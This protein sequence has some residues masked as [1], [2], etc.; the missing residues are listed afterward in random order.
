M[1]NLPFNFPNFSSRVF[2]YKESKRRKIRFKKKTKNL[3]SISFKRL[4]RELKTS[5]NF[6]FFA[7]NKID[8][9][10]QIHIYLPL[11]SDIATLLTTF[12][13][14]IPNLDTS[15]LREP[16]KVRACQEKALQALQTYTL[17][18][19]HNLPSKFGELLL[20]IPELQRTCQVSFKNLIFCFI[21]FFY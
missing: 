13:I 20:R 8:L 11:V 12:S 9:E 1:S 3:P 19:Y 10:R 16:E 6:R 17:A 4:S 18:H 15:D 14:F 21:F 2:F 5:Q 7:F